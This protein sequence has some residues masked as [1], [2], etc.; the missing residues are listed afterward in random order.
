MNSQK[1]KNKKKKKII[2]IVI[3]IL[4]LINQFQPFDAIAAALRLDETGY[5]YT[6]ISFTNGQKLENK[7]IWNMKMDGK[8]VF[9]ID[10]AAPANTEDGYSASTYTGEEKRLII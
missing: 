10:S 7:D 8:D 1:R 4:I 9:C 5:F 3:V 2:A 6:G